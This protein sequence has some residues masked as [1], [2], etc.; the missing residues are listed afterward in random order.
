MRAEEVATVI[1]E[2]AFAKTTPPPALNIVNPRGVPWANLVAS[3]REAIVDEMNLCVDD[4]P[5][6]PF[7]E[8]FC[9][10][11]KRAEG[12]CSEDMA[13]VVRCALGLVSADDLD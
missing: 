10:L 9:L 8:W 4:I 6:V 13:R 12:A 11:E 3:V 2:V 5:T 7:R 1:L